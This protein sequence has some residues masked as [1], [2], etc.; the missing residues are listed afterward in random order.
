[1]STLFDYCDSDVNLELEVLRIAKKLN[2]PFTADDL[3]VLDPSVKKLG[4]DKRVYGAILRSL[5]S[6][7]K[8]CSLGYVKST[9]ETCHNRPILQW[10]MAK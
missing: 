3:H 9:R 8:L 6:Q 2:R 5:G 4:R 10:E 1:M 7:G